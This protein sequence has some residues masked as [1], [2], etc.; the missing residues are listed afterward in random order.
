MKIRTTLKLKPSNCYI[1]LLTVTLFYFSY[2]YVFQWANEITSGSY[3]KTPIFVQILKYVICFLCVALSLIYAICNRSKFKVSGKVYFVVS[4]L[5]FLSAAYAFIIV[6]DQNTLMLFV[7]MT[8]VFMMC[9]TINEDI[10]FEK[11]DKLFIIFV[12]INILYEFFQI[13]LYVYKK[14]LPAIAWPDAGLMQVRFGGMFDDPLALS[15][16]IGF[17]IPYIYHKFQGSKRNVYIIIHLLMLV[18]TWTLTSTFALIGVF[19]IDRLYVLAKGKGWNPIRMLL[20][21]GAAAVGIVMMLLRGEAFYNRIMEVKGGSIAI[22]METRSLEGMSILTFLGITPKAHYAESSITRLLF[23]NGFFF[24]IL[25]YFLGVCSVYSFNN[26]IN[27]LQ[28]SMQKYRPILYGM[29]YYQLAF[30]I[31]SINLP[32][33]YMFFNMITFSVFAGVSFTVRSTMR[34][35]R[36]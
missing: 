18:L 30:M 24:T 3:S 2:R 17:I 14:R 10:S 22:H 15:L 20:L 35:E 11:I 31:G 23:T 34:M 9:V 28:S 12:N 4:A 13:S 19:I 16:F 36:V 26:I 33:P 1:L 6:K 5:L 7:G 32:F 27:T 25:F 8:I 21:L 29:M